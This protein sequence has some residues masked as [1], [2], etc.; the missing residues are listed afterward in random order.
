MRSITIVEFGDL[1]CP[2]CKAAQPNITKLMEEEP[3]TRLDLSAN[4]P[5]ETDP[6]VGPCGRKISGLRGAAEQ[7][8]GMEVHRHRI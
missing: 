2:A 3:K 5:L 8:R 4:Y 1:E 7:P 6:Q